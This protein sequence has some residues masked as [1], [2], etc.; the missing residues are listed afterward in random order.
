MTT[1]IDIQNLNLHIAKKNIVDSLSLQIQPGQIWG[2][3]GP[4]GC[5]KTTF[6]QTLAGLHPT[7]SGVIFLQNKNL[8]S[9]SRKDIAKKI[10]ILFQDTHFIFPQTVFE[11]C[12]S[13]RHPHNTTQKENHEIVMRALI[14][15]ELESLLDHKTFTLSGG[16]KRRLA[17]AAVIAQTPDVYLL[18]E[19]TNHLDLRHQMQ[20]LQFFKKLSETTGAGIVMTLHDLS[21]AKRFCDHILMIFGEGE[22]LHGKT[23]DIVNNENLSRLYQYPIE[24][25]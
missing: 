19:P 15:M 9:Y 11:F 22:A 10:G 24:V 21:A 20:T 5:G 12:L 14:H 16:E 17:I 13:G 1:L 8:H 2:I 3:L 4:N 7:T 23:P 18:D 25:C 6:L